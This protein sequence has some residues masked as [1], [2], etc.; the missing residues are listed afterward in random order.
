MTSDELRRL[1]AEATPGPWRYP[2]S[3]AIS[4]PPRPITGAN[5]VADWNGTSEDAALIV[6]AVKALPGLLDVVD[7]ARWLVAMPDAI[8]PHSTHWEDIA[9]LRDALARLDG[10]S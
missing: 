5:V 10:A 2:V 6:A 7:A 1:L 3:G 4:C 9:D 8:E